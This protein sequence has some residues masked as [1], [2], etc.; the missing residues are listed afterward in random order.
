[1][2][3]ALCQPERAPMPA[4]EQL[5]VLLAATEGLLE[6]LD[7]AAVPPAMDRVRDAIREDDRGIAALIAEGRRLE[8]QDRATSWWRRAPR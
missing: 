2:R 7:E 3:A 5:A 1:M 6:G 4:P 8:P